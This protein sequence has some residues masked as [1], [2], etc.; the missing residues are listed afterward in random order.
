MPAPNASSGAR[1]Q[2]GQRAWHS[3]DLVQTH[4]PKPDCSE[5]RPVANA[6]AV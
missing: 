6:R 2:R 3:R 5:Y 1:M 4:F